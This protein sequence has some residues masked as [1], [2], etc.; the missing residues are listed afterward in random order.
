MQRVVEK[1]CGDVQA[2]LANGNKTYFLTIKN[3]QKYET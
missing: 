1:R 2:F 3:K